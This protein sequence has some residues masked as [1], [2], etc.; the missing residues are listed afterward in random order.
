LPGKGESV[1]LYKWIEGRAE[2][3]S[4]V[5]LIVNLQAKFRGIVVVGK[6]V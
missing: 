3:R 4:S 5:K 6:S 1:K 2:E